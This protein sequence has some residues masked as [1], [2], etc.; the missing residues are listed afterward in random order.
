[1]MTIEKKS[2]KVGKY[3]D[4]NHVDTVIRQYKQERWVENSKR[5]GKEDSLSV[6]YS[7]EEL[8]QF[9][10]KIKDNGANGIRFY[11]AEYPAGFMPDPEVANRQTIV[12]V[13]TK[14]KEKGANCS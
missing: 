1:M 4:T 7:V 14:S 2:L 3:V 11:F 9:I 8:E 10:A 12:L 5:I 13:A 6:W